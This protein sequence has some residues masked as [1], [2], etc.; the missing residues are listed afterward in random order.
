[1]DRGQITILIAD[2]D[3]STKFIRPWDKLQLKQNRY[4]LEYEKDVDNLF[5]ILDY[6]EPITF[7]SGCF[8][9]DAD[10]KTTI[11]DNDKEQVQDDVVKDDKDGDE[12]DVVKDV[13]QDDVDVNIDAIKDIDQDD[14]AIDI[15]AN[16]INVDCDTDILD[17]V[18]KVD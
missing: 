8:L 15:Y 6:C 14:N 9:D 2:E 7:M 16:T 12:D 13:D 11:E 17:D 4:G 1:M 5:Y 10:R 3:N 18:V